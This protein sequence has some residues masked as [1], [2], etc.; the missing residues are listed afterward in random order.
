[1]SRIIVTGSRNWSKPE[2]VYET[3]EALVADKENDVIVHGDC[4]TGADHFAFLWC[5]RNNVKQERYPADW[6]RF[7]KSAG[8]RRNEEMVLKGADVCV[9]FPILGGSNGT[10]DCM[11]RAKQAGITVINMGEEYGE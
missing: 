4:P 6:K 10:W 2:R 7:G 8:P 9:G 3:L 1:M 5:T 11:N